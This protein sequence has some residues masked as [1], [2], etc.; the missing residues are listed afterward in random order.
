MATQVLAELLARL[1]SAP[2]SEGLRQ[3]SDIAAALR[4]P[5]NSSWYARA[6]PPWPN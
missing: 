6:R 1:T 5:P 4:D 3:L 2:A